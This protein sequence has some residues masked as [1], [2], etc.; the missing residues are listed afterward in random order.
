M[1]CMTKDILSLI[2]K[3]LCVDPSKALKRH[4]PA[5]KVSNSQA[6]DTELK[7][8]S[9]ITP[10]PMRCATVTF[11]AHF[12]DQSQAVLSTGGPHLFFPFSASFLSKLIGAH[13]YLI[14]T[15]IANCLK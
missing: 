15:Q 4:F 1:L 8:E 11:S 12:K 14:F 6:H 13:N 3:V 7:T 5:L 10:S 2:R 9:E